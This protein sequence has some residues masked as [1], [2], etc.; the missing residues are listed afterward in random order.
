VLAPLAVLF[1]ALATALL[2]LPAAGGRGLRCDCDPYAALELDTGRA[3]TWRWL[4]RRCGRVRELGPP[5]PKC[6]G[7][8]TA[9]LGDR[10]VCPF[11]GRGFR[12]EDEAAGMYCSACYRY[13]DGPC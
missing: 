4:C 12:V 11:C 13:H 6:P 3:G 5:C 2:A 10:A 8:D 9:I 7:C 1:L